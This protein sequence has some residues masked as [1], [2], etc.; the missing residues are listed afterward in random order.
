MIQRRQ[1]IC[2]S[3]IIALFTALFFVPVFQLIYPDSNPIPRFMQNHK[4]VFVLGILSAAFAMLAIFV[5]KRNI[6]MLLC[7]SGVAVSILF[8]ASIFLLSSFAKFLPYDDGSIH[9]SGA[10]LT[11]LF[12]VLFFVAAYF[13]KKDIH[14]IKAADQLR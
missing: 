10:W 6:Q 8:V 14:L 7:Y 13:I 11:L 5:R 3:L 1:T 12:P 9:F 2:L 4:I